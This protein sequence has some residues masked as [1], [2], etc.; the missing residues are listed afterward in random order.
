[1]VLVVSSALFVA[2]AFVFQGRQAR[3]EFTQSVRNLEAK[4]QTIATEASSSTYQTAN[5]RAGSTGPPSFAVADNNG[6]CIFLGKVLL[7]STTSTESSVLTMIGRRQEGDPPVDVVSIDQASGV[8]LR[9]A[10]G[11]RIVERVIH[12]YGLQIRKMVRQGSIDTRV[13]GIGFMNALSGSARST[14]AAG[15]Q[16]YGLLIPDFVNNEISLGPNGFVSLSDG[17]LIC[18]QG[19]NGQRAEIRVGGVSSQSQISTELDTGNGGDCDA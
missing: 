5:C 14:P 15:M 18:L 9:D 16:L 17:V 2:I 3:T 4:L 7:P 11:E 19:Q 13:Y 12:S 8:V 10:G 1:M 6:S